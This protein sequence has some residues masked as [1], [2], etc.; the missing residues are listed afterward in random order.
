MAHTAALAAENEAADG[1]VYNCADTLALS[2]R[3]IVEMIAEIMDHKWEIVSVPRGLM[4]SVPQS[5][6]LPYSCDPYDIEPHMLLDLTKIRTE[7]GY[8]D[9][10][11]ITTA[12][13]N[14]VRWLVDER[15]TVDWLSPSYPDHNEAIRKAEQ[16]ARL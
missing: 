3:Q 11:P 7:L 15:P 8:E 13:K 16:I 6:G 14:T 9:L 2:L 5:Q 12:L 4:P 10:V 1:Q